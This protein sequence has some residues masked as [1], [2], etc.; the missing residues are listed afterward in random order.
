MMLRESLQ[1]GY[2]F[3]HDHCNTS[4]FT[5]KS[6]S[7][8]NFMRY[9]AYFVPSSRSGKKCSKTSSVSWEEYPHKTDPR[10]SIASCR[11]R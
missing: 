10:A 1:S 2:S 4:V 6:Q 11:L 8:A 7:S 9:L 3:E 5:A